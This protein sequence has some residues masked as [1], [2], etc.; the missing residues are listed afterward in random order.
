MI[1]I[2]IA[3]SVFLLDWNIKKYIEDHFD[4]G[5]KKDILKGKVTVRKQYNRGFSLNILDNKVELVKKITG[6]IFAVLIL[7]YI[8][9]LPQRNKTLKKIG[10]SLCTGGAASNVL[11]RFKN[12]HVVDYFSF[13][14]KPIKHIVF[15]LADIFILL[16]SFITF[17]SYLM[18]PEAKSHLRD[19]GVTNSI[20][21]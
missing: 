18:H 19:S 13:N 6:V 9:I 3:L 2:I 11:D 21:E 4:I 1:Y 10:L 8:I 20:E 17:L 14:C 15:N 12:G 16:G 7:T 5:E